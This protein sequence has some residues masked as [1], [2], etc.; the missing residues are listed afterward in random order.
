VD[1]P[2][3]G[4]YGQNMQPLPSG[5]YRHEDFAATSAGKPIQAFGGSFVSTGIRNDLQGM[6][7]PSPGH[8]SQAQMQSLGWSN[9][10]NANQ[11]TLRSARGQQIPQQFIGDS[12]VNFQESQYVGGGGHR[13]L[14]RNPSQGKNVHFNQFSQ[15]LEYSP[16]K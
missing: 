7:D 1:T 4:H 11:G 16:S 15:T 10:F 5:I 3:R 8:H 14:P 9:V 12:R 2:S 13:S 6:I